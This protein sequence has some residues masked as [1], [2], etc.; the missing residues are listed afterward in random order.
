MRNKNKNGFTLIELLVVVAIIGLLSSIVLI[1]LNSARASARDSTRMAD[2]SQI[3]KALEVY[4]DDNAAYPDTLA[5]LGTGPVVYMATVPIPPTPPDNPIGT[6]VCD[7]TTNQYVYEPDPVDHLTYTL[8]FC[9]G[10][11]TGSYGPGIHIVN[12]SGVVQ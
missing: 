3:S 8:T 12:P 11:Q 4:Y 9:L 1:A 2:I 7:D 5:D 6:S 10:G